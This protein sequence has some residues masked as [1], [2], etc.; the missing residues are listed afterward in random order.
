MSTFRY[1]KYWDVHGNSFYSI[2]ERLPNGEWEEI[3]RW[4]FIQSGIPCNSVTTVYKEVMET[5]NRLISQG[6]TVI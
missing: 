2:E 4:Y 5:V 3:K 1:E 6:H